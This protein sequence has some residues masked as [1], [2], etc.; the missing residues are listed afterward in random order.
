VPTATRGG[1]LPLRLNIT[2]YRKFPSPP[3]LAP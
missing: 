3:A 2:I 1:R